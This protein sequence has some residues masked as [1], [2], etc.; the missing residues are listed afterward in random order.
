M[1]WLLIFGLDLLRHVFLQTLEDMVKNNYGS[2]DF[3][4]TYI[5]VTVDR[6]QRPIYRL[7]LDTDTSLSVF[8][9]PDEYQEIAVQKLGVRSPL[10]SLSTKSQ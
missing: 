6:S 2:T 7:I 3:T 4:V 9:S 1:N 10:H 8:M 5:D